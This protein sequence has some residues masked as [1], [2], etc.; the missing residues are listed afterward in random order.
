MIVLGVSDE[1]PP[2]LL[3]DFPHSESVFAVS[4]GLSQET[5]IFFRAL[6]SLVGCLAFISSP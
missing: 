5:F 4:E 3:L 2:S 6:A 1:Y